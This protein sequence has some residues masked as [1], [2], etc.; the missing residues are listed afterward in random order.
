MRT[1]LKYRRACMQGLLTLALSTARF[2]DRS[3]RGD[4]S[5]LTHFS[6][7]RFDKDLPS[8]EGGY[9]SLRVKRTLW[10]SAKELFIR[11][12]LSLRR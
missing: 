8:K 4:P 10:D 9:V 6:D 7:G 11:D 12:S 5:P 1:L 2:G 3:V